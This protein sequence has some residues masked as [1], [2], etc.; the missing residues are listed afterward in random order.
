[1]GLNQ[2]FGTKVG[3]NWDGFG[4]QKLVAYFGDKGQGKN[5]RHSGGKFRTKKT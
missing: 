2:I 3:E 4:V 5:Q 1:M